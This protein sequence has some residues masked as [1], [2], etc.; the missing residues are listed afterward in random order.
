MKT[1]LTTTAALAVI[2]APAVI[3]STCAATNPN[4]HALTLF[5]F[6]FFASCSSVAFLYSFTQ[7]TK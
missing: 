1:L 4:G 7:S 2:V 5:S 6:L 3:V